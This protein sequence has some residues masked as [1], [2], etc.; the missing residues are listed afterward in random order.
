VC[1]FPVQQKVNGFP[2]AL[3]IDLTIQILINHL[4]TLFGCDIRQNIRSGIAGLV[5]ISRCPQVSASIGQHRC[6]PGEHVSFYIAHCS[7][8]R[9][10]FMPIEHIDTGADHLQMAQFLSRHIQKQILYLR[11]FNA[12]ALR[13][14][15]KSAFQFSLRPAQLF[16][17]Q[18]RIVG[19]RPVHMYRM[20]KLFLMFEHLS[21]LPC[22]L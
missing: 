21:H 15:L 4:R 19:I 7:I 14:I 18:R 5:N 11:I 8:L 1:L 6:Q 2:Y 16:L 17:Q 9:I 20:Q 13:Q 10:Q 12:H 22:I 3:V